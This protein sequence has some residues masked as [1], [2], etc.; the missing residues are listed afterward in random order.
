MDTTYFIDFDGTIT[1][2][3]TTAAMA[4]AFV[5]RADFPAIM[6]ITEL[7]E[8]KELSTRECAEQIFGYFNADLDDMLRLLG[9]VEI[10][11]GFLEFVDI[12]RREKDPIYVLSDGFDLGIRTVFKKYAIEMPF[13]SNTMLYNDGFHVECPHAN[14]KCGHCGV[15]KTSLLQRLKEPGHTCIYIGDGYSDICPAGHADTVF[16][17]EP[18]FTLCRKSDIDAVGFASFSHIVEQ[19]HGTAPKTKPRL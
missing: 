4:H 10:D 14:L 18:L 16:A 15:C 8:R 11:P 9:T 17:K 13:Y 1:T 6:R 5:S 2:I 3:D 19:L 12:C 7:W